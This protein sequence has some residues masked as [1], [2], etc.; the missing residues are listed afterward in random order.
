MTY[1]VFMIYMMLV[2]ICTCMEN[3]PS[4]LTGILILLGNVALCV[5]LC[6]S[7]KGKENNERRN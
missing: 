4:A 1:L 2:Y 6:L 5:H 3:I 7:D